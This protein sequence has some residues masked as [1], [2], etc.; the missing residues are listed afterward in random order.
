MVTLTFSSCLGRKY[1]LNLHSNCVSGSYLSEMLELIVVCT[2]LAITP[3]WT[4]KS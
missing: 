3:S 1:V 4:D 2:D